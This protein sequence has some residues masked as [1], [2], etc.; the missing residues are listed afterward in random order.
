M[1]STPLVAFVA[2]V[3]VLVQLAGALL[4]VGL[5][6]LLRRFVLRRGYF[7]AWTWAWEALAVALAAV[8]LRVHL[9]RPEQLAAWPAGAALATPLRGV[10]LFAKLFMVACLVAGTVT[11]ATGRRADRALRWTAAGLAAFAALAAPLMGRSFAVYAGLQAPFVI[12]GLGS[13]AL[14]LL[15]L[16]PSRRTLGNRFVA[17]GFLTTVVLWCVYPIAFSGPWGGVA[18]VLLDGVADYSSYL[19]LVSQMVLG[20][21][22]VVALMEDAKNEVHDAQAELR[23][24]HDRLLRDALY[25]PLTGALNRRAFAEGVGL[26]LARASFGCVALLVLDNLKEVND[27]HGHPAGDNLLCRVVESIRVGMR[28]SDRVFR[29]GGDEFLIVVPHGRADE[30]RARVEGLLAAGS[31]G[32]IPLEVSVGAVDFAGAE[33]LEAAIALADAGMYREKQRRRIA[34][35]TPH[36]MTAIPAPYQP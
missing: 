13:A 32:T 30:V 14:L 19:D 7:R 35:S 10:Y 29:W 8:V 24:A 3:G 18:G 6:T 16:P 23:I 36:A 1:Q 22:M 9:M 21:A 33:G 15:R 11:Y 27:T 34:R 26:E 31:D 2:F 20:Y 4:L 25:D 17:A 28:A 12:A 5:F